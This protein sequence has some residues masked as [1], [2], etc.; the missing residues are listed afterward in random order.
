M[1]KSIRGRFAK[2]AARAAEIGRGI[3]I[4]TL[5]KSRIPVGGGGAFSTAAVK[6]GECVGFYEGARGATEGSDYVVEGDGG[7]RRDA[8]DAEGRLVLQDGTRV[9]V[10]SWTAA[11][12]SGLGSPATWDGATSNWTRFVNHA[13][14]GFQ[15]VTIATTSTRFG[16]SHAFYAKKD[17]QAGDELFFSY[18]ASYWKFRN[19][20][21]MDPEPQDPPEPIASVVQDDLP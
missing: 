18:G 14:A 4:K 12:W 11:E 3:V 2:I 7:A 16:R 1:V 19:I 5:R 21:P 13:S 10:H 20:A 8:S 17:I 9:N 6:R 15:N